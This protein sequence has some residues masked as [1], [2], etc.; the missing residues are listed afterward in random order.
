MAQAQA[1]HRLHSPLWWHHRG[2]SC[3]A[4]KQNKTMESVR[5]SKANGFTATSSPPSLFMC[6]SIHR[7][8]MVPAM[9]D[10]DSFK[11]P[12]KK[13]KRDTCRVGRKQFRKGV[14]NQRFHLK[15]VQMF[16]Y[17]FNASPYGSGM[18]FGDDYIQHCILYCHTQTP[19]SPYNMAG[20]TGWQVNKNCLR[21][22]PFC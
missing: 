18:V 14:L 6:K 9:H 15:M 20:N 3:A 2:E 5:H 8:L 4:R 16:V 19:F 21:A 17:R 13:K 12:R 10:T 11:W 22:R 1:F 7:V